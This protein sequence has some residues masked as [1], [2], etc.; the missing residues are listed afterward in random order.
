MPMDDPYPFEWSDTKAESNLEKHGVSFW[1]ASTVFRD[2]L[3]I[4]IQD[5]DDAERFVDTG[6][7]DR[8]RLLVVVYCERGAKIRIISAR[9]AERHERQDYENG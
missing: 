8:H 3:S 7:S 5:P 1:E 6:L 2:P 9:E 4:T